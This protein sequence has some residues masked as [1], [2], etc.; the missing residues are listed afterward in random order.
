MNGIATVPENERRALEGAPLAAVGGNAPEEQPLQHRAAGSWL[1]AHE[2]E[3]HVAVVGKQAPRHRPGR[4][5]ERPHPALA[6]GERDQQ[7]R[8][9]ES[10]P[11]QGVV[12][13]GHLDHHS[14]QALRLL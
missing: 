12:E 4:S 3:H 2:I 11:Q 9:G 8:E 1:L 14:P 5:R 7:R 13:H 6:E 10:A